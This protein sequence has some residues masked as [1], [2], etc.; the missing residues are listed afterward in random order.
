MDTQYLREVNFILV[1]M[2]A[3][4]V[5]RGN[6]KEWDGLFNFKLTT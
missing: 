3:K 2:S 1:C 6:G 4:I 5:K